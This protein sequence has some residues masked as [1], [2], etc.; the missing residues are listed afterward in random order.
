MLFDERLV[1]FCCLDD[2]FL[3]IGGEYLEICWEGK[4]LV[5]RIGI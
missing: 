4:N 3:F 5:G 2:V 1:F